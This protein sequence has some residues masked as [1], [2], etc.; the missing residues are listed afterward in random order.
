[1]A[2]K[3]FS[4]NPLDFPQEKKQQLL[5][6]SLIIIAL[7][8]IAVLY[9]GFLRPSSTPS[10]ELPVEEIGQEGLPAVGQEGIV[11]GIPEGGALA[12]T[13][14]IVEK[15][16]FDVSFLKGDSFQALESYGSWPI[17]IGEKGRSNPFL[18]Y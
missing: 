5:I 18:P 6:V 15:I 11:G 17:E 13:E 10:S 2:F 16:D 7:I 14:G 9:F 4:K 12:G 8:I 1:M 3:L